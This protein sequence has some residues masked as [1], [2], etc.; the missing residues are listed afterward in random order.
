MSSKDPCTS[1]IAFE[2]EKRV[3]ENTL[4]FS[5]KKIENV[6]R[7]N[8]ITKTNKLK[9]GIVI[10]NPLTAKIRY[11]VLEFLSFYSTGS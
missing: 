7:V 1:K 5:V 6:L 8:P 10:L 11:L 2:A 4:E 3:K 9:D